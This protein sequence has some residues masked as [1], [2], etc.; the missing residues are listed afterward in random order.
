MNIIIKKPIISEKSM[1]LAGE[2]LYSF[3]VD[4][5]ATK[6]II[7]RV[8]EELFAVNVISV[9]ISR[10]KELIKWQRSRRGRFTLSGYKKA[11][12]KIKPGQKIG[13]FESEEKKEVKV[14]KAEDEVREKKSLLKGTKVKIEKTAKDEVKK[15]KETKEKKGKK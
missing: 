6:P 12:V 1:K 15:E 13:L 8:V 11:V 14:I 2:N 10:F 5:K 4:N 7:A 9:K 3:V